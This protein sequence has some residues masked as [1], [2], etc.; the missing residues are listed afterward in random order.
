[1]IKF[2]NFYRLVFLI[3]FLIIN[4]LIYSQ[5]NKIDFLISG[6]SNTQLLDFDDLKQS[7]STYTVNFGIS[8][9]FSNDIYLKT[10]L[11]LAGLAP[12]NDFSFNSYQIP[13]LFG[14]YFFSKDPKNFR[15]F[16]EFGPH[17]RGIYDFNNF[18]EENYQE[19][20]SFGIIF[21]TG[22][23]F[24]LN[25]RFFSRIF[26]NTN[27]DFGDSFLSDN[28]KVRITNHSIMFGIGLKF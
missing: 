16:A 26:L 28:N 7:V 12:I 15:F 24:D 19:K 21:N 13:L 14:F 17:L 1:M 10:G 23:H 8:Y 27:K 3:F 20:E 2:I 9:N 6:G 5:E 11:N 4:T 18:S 25:N 22:M